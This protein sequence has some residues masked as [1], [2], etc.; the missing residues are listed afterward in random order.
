MNWKS[1]NVQY[2]ILGNLRMNPK[3]NNGRVINTIHRMLAPVYQKYPQK[4]RL[5]KTIGTSEK[6]ELYEIKY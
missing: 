5:V 6:T 2:V 4:I 1:L 3:K